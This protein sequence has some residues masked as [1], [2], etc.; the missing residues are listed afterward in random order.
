M[1]TSIELPT[2]IYD[3]LR[4]EALRR[5]KT[6]EEIIIEAL[7]KYLDPNISI[8]AYLELHEKYLK[9]AEEYLVKGDLTQAGEK[10]WS[11]IASLLNAIAVKKGW[12]HYSHRDYSEI[13]ERIAEELNKPEIS[14]WFALAERM[15]A[16]YYHNFIRSRHLFENYRQDILKLVKILKEYI[17]S[18]R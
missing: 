1:D 4:K 14:K 2:T 6:I 17:G 12:P 9:E 3:I 11:A 16:N 5:G 8:K 15:H 10:Y 18:L 7:A 13:I